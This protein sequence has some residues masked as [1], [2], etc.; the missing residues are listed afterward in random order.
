MQQNPSQRSIRALS[1]MNFSLAD[2]R[3]GLGPFL[4]V[5]LIGHG[6]AADEIGYVMTLGGLAGM[7]ATTPLGALVDATRFKRTIIAA[8]AGLIIVGTL[9]LLIST[10]FWVVAGSQIGTSV[11]AAIIA[12][13]IAGLT[14][15]LVGQTGLARQLG[16]NQAWNHGGN[17]VSA[18]LAGAF[19]YVFGLIAV[20]VL[21][22]ILAIAS[23][24]S[25]YLIK[26]SEIDHDVARGLE[27]SA[28][29]RNREPSSIVILLKSRALVV[30]GITIFLFHFGNAAM[31][32]LLSQSVVSRGLADPS[33]Y[34]SA[35]III[36]Q[37]TMIPMA[38]IA[39]WVAQR[40]GFGIVVMAALIA[41]PVRGLIA[42]YWDNPWALIPVQ[43]LDGVGAGLL[44]VA[45]P[46]MVAR[47]LRGTG[48]VN[49]G[50]G[51]VMTMHNV[52]AALS[53]ALGGFV[54]AHYG[55]ANAFLA[56]A[57]VATAALIFWAVG[58][59]MEGK[60]YAATA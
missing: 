46:G 50:I 39:A 24:I 23:I 4:G 28:Q 25:V 19:G 11:F 40:R 59:R 47:L 22:I 8:A 55:Y 38:L 31:L 6:W 37:G 57:A 52:G 9:A 41:L 29:H 36:A 10:N 53:P 7:L 42:G 2:V 43:V 44:G 14:L 45:T 60:A 58:S 5:F 56:L 51:G 13:A 27:P 16:R 54:A 26:P 18:I 30:F 48:H 33:A 21:M 20:F 17:V 3:D 1:A 15:G 35:T 34:T 49:L 12:P 32:P